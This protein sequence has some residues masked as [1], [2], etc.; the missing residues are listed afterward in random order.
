V[1]L[2][3]HEEAQ[4]R[5]ITAQL[6]DEDPAFG[7]PRG[8]YRAWEAIGRTGV[9]VLALAGGLALL[10]ASAATGF[11]PLGMLGYLVATLATA[12]LAPLL[13]WR[14]TLRRSPAPADRAPSR[15]PTGRWSRAALAAAVVA[16]VAVGVLGPGGEASSASGAD[17]APAATEVAEEPRSSGDRTPPFARR[18]PPR[19][20]ASTPGGS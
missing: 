3:A 7:R 5:R 15:F 18:N 4:F 17:D 1:P 8:R 20:A 13:P 16:V 2:D 14:P 9:P 12:R 19:V 6:L 10:P 11:Y